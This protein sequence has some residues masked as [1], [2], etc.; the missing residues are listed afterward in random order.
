[1]KARTLLEK[2]Y[3]IHLLKAGRRVHSIL[4]VVN[5]NKRP[6]VRTFSSLFGT[7]ISQPNHSQY[8]TCA[9]VS[10]T[11]KSTTF[12]KYRIGYKN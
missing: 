7:D 3:K 4:E 8:F 1:M 10:V 11:V 9:T 6:M 2:I 12:L 5:P